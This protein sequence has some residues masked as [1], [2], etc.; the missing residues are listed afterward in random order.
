MAT[1]RQIK[2]RITQLIK[3]FRETDWGK[4]REATDWL[5]D[6]L[7]EAQLEQYR[8]ELITRLDENDPGDDAT[9]FFY[10]GTAKNDL[11]DYQAAIADYD[12][13][14]RLNPELAEAFN[15]RGNAKDELGDHAGAIADYDEAIRL[16]PDD[17][18]AFHNRGI[19]KFN[20]K[21][22]PGAIAD[23]DEA[24]RLKPDDAG[25]LHNRG[26]AKL[27]LAESRQDD[28]SKE[29]EENR[30]ERLKKELER[31]NGALNDF[32]QAMRLDPTDENIKIFE[33]LI[34]YITNLSK[35]I[36]F[37]KE[38]L[39]ERRKNEEKQIRMA[40]RA[41]LWLAIAL[42]AIIPVIFFILPDLLFLPEDPLNG[43]GKKLMFYFNAMPYGLYALIAA[44]FAASI[45][46]FVMMLRQTHRLETRTH[47]SKHPKTDFILSPEAFSP[48][49]H[50]NLEGVMEK[51]A[52][53]VAN[54][55][56]FD[57]P[58]P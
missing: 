17:A 39:E 33:S 11:K 42:I 28:T 56:T 27:K 8:Q 48:D 16:K 31:E 5:L 41:A 23:F 57:Q 34:R 24:L 9:I 10:L 4:F 55:V 35:N 26:V 58:N 45:S 19:S 21:D 29:A 25:A 6:T 54:K 1:D 20:M 3:A 49:L 12:E 7:D 18:G 22:N 15:N 13:A 46:V 14:I 2:T 32:R 43:T 47:E 53:E 30:D 50:K 51:V 37:K 44:G 36:E 52:K 38:E 40:T